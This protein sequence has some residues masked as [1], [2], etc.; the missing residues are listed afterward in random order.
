MNN[1]R[2]FKN[3]VLL[4]H[5][6]AQLNSADSV[7]VTFDFQKSDEKNQSVTQHA[8]DDPVM[9]PVRAWATTIHWIQNYPIDPK[10]LMHVP[11]NMVFVDGKRFIISAELLL[12]KI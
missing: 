9:C 1:I 5:H 4:P 12:A 11:I 7:C 2:F 3:Q 8:M 10:E 6:H